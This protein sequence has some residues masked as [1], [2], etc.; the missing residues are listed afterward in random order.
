MT[1]AEN[2]AMDSQHDLDD[3]PQYRPVCGTA[4]VAMVFAVVSTLAILGPVF[5]GLPLFTLGLGALAL[6]RIS[7]NDPP[8]WGRRLALAAMFW[9][10]LCGAAG[11]GHWLM[12]AYLVRQQ[13][14]QWA[15]AWFTHMLR[16]ETA[17]AHQQTLNAVHRELRLDELDQIYADNP[18]LE[19]QLAEYVRLPGPALVL[20][21]GSDAQLTYLHVLSQSREGDEDYVWLAYEI[22]DPN[23]P[24]RRSKVAICLKRHTGKPPGW[25]VYEAMSLDDYERRQLRAF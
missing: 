5:W 16:G 15:H 24:Q 25:M 3:L 19:E 11:L 1:T 4:V 13:A 9:A 12:H 18:K 17:Q 21:F 10:V 14:Q 8:L 22:A 6:R 23:A 2:P 20:S 7:A